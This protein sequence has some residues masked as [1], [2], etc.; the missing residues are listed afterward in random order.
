MWWAALT[1][2]RETGG[3]TGHINY[4]S[5]HADLGKLSN[6]GFTYNGVTRAIDGL[7]VDR[8]GHFQIWVDSGD[9]SALPN[10]AVLHVGNQSVT[11]GS[12]TR[13]SFKTIYN[14]GPAPT[15][16]ED[17]YWWQSGSHGVSLSDRQVVAAWLEVPAGSELPGTPRSVNA[18]ARD[19][20]ANLEWVAPPE[21][22]SKPVTSYEYQQEGT[23]DVELHGRNGD[24]KGG[25]GS[26]QRRELHLPGAGS[27]RGGQGR[28]VGAVECGD[29]YR[30]GDACRVAHGELRVGSGGA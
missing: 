15:M 29:A 17:T 27:E 19:G 28:G 12:A 8:N 9:G 14:D 20:K 2:R 16:R 25:G 18:Q 24:D 26:R 22:P 21:V 11:L 23:E 1:A 10:S 7:F 13:H 6:S 3:A 30:C 4:T 5:P